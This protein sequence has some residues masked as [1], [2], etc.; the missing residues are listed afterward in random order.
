[1]SY[2]VHWFYSPHVNYFRLGLEGN[3]RRF[4]QTI[5]S[6]LLVVGHLPFVEMNNKLTV[7]LFYL[8]CSN[9][10]FNPLPEIFLSW[11]LT[12][13]MFSVCFIPNIFC[14]LNPAGQNVRQCQSPLPGISRSLPHTF[15]IFREDWI[16]YNW[17]LE[18]WAF[19]IN[20]CP[21]SFLITT[22][23]TAS[24]HPSDCVM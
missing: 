6:L 23:I 9:G 12:N 24:S 10:H 22:G 19:L 18:Y 17:L 15:G 5:V 13:I 16:I 20:I 21:R 7:V 8:Q 4:K 14:A 2:L 3:G 1:M 11:W